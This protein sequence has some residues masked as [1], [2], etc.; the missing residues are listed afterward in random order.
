MEIYNT[1]TIQT[2]TRWAT[3]ESAFFYLPCSRQL[4]QVAAP[5]YV[6][7]PHLHGRIFSTTLHIVH[8]H[9]EV[10]ETLRG[11]VEG[12]TGEGPEQ[13]SEKRYINPVVIC[14]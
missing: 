9:T 2:E 7:Y 13:L 12:V 10:K 3:H 4:K 6:E 8:T 1:Y 11:P 14:T 5:C